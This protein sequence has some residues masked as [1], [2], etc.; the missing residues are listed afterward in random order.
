M[1]TELTTVDAELERL[2][3]LT[4]DELR[5]ELAGQLRLTASH[6]VRLAAIVRLLEDRGEDLSDLRIGLLQYLRRIAH[7]QVVPEVVVRFAE[8]PSL[9]QRISGMPLPDQ[10]RLASGDPVRLMDASGEHRLMDPLAMTRD[11]VAQAFAR[12]HIRDDAEQIAL[13]TGRVARPG[14]EPRR[15]QCRPDATRGGIVVR[16]TFVP[17]GDALEALA[18]LRG[19][20]DEYVTDDDEPAMLTIKI[21]AAEQQLLKVLAA[22][23]NCTMTDLVRRALYAAGVLK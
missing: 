16:R 2:G 7:G 22:Q 15:G 18:K 3:G 11:Q 19:M 23:S 13:I 21:T 5:G 14:R 6:L 20:A 17:L 1:T 8:Y 9:I 4:T 10:I 12:D